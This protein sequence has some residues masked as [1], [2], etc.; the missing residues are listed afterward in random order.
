MGQ[1]ACQYAT[2]SASASANATGRVLAIRAAQQLP[3]VLRPRPCRPA[4]RPPAA[5]ARLFG[6]PNNNDARRGP[7]QPNT[8]PL[9]PGWAAPAATPFSCPSHPATSSPSLRHSAKR[10]AAASA[11]SESEQGGYQG[12]VGPDYDPKENAAYWSTRPATVGN[13]LVEI[14]RVFGRWWVAAWLESRRDI[15]SVRDNELPPINSA[16]AARLRE[17]L[18]GLG[19][20]FVKIGQAIASR[21]D[22]LPPSYLKELEKL[23]DEIPSFPTEDALALM[24][25]EY[26]RPAS[27]IFDSLSPEPLAAAS[28]GQVYKGTLKSTGEVVAVKVQ[29][30][31]VYE[32][33][34]L[35]LFI[36]RR[37]A[38]SLRRYFKA[39]TDLPQL[40]DEWGA[41]LYR[42]LDY[43][44][45]A[46]NGRR[47]RR[48]F[49]HIPEVYVPIMHESVTTPRVLVMEWLDGTK[50]RSASSGY[51]P[52]PA[53]ATAAADNLR[54]VE[55]G[56]RC[57]LEQMLEEGFYH[58]DPH[59]GNL[60][61]MKDGRLAY[62]DFGMMG[63]IGLPIR[64]GLIRATLHLVN[65]EYIALADDFVMLG[66]LP[67]DSKRDEIVPALTGMFQ[68]ALKNG[69]ANLSFVQL[70][71]KLGRTM[72]QYKFRIPPYYTLLVRS[73]SVLEGIALSTDPN[74]KVLG[75]AYPWVARRLLTDRD[76]VLRETLEAL[77]YRNGKFQFSRLESLLEQAAK[78][79][80]RDS[81]IAARPPPPGHKPAVLAEGGPAGSEGR[82][83][84]QASAPFPLCAGDATSPAG[85]ASSSAGGPLTNGAIQLV[86]SEDGDF[87]RN[88]VLEEIARGLDAAVRI[89]LDESVKA[90]KSTV[91]TLLGVAGREK[92][93]RAGVFRDY[94]GSS[95]VEAVV[96][97]PNLAEAGDREQIEG[98]TRLSAQLQKLAGHEASGIPE[99]RAGRAASVAEAAALLRW[100]AEEVGQLPS[101]QR[102]E[103]LRIPATLAQKVSSRLTARTIRATLSANSQL[104]EQLGQITDVASLREWASSVT[105]EESAV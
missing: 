84:G 57:S 89:Q 37:L 23:H 34:S 100:L 5:A 42:E 91:L 80:A 96:A 48:L 99:S 103:A 27:D 14:G 58:A 13:R 9:I 78:S 95:L 51:G 50:L 39:N 92:D 67:P 4:R 29:R 21:P 10:H 98:L 11:A 25:E 61:R 44:T 2:V 33:I 1:H 36:L 20:A 73:L 79:P 8:P 83:Q 102:G 82:P 43:T 6:S 68:E 69:V 94:P 59:P 52:T 62:L 81:L 53:D 65:R 35:D 71:G 41:S 38:G 64:R 74:Y 49:G 105:P 40:L 55:V 24:A 18:T 97:L 16:S 75:S 47:F 31:G 22:L 72:Y 56:V 60:L 85:G 46:A 104:A 63:N 93:V 32:S 87:I 76:P 17:V 15:A 26:G 88:I 66:L 3:P 19:P 30:P 86:L 28:L 12:Y 45:E 90:A 7:R 77:L 70:S 101:A 54:L